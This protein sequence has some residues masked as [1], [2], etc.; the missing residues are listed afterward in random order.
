[1]RRAIIGALALLGAANSAHGQSSQVVAGR[2][3][4]DSITPLAGAIVSVT[5]APDRMFKQD[6]TGPDGRWRIRFEKAS[7]DYLVHIAA[8]GRTSFRKRVTAPLSDPV[9]AVDAT[10]A[11]SVQQL[12]A[13]RVQA[14]RPKPTR[15]G[16]AFLPDG[17]SSEQ[18]PAG[19]T[20]AVTADMAGDLAAMAGSIPGLALT[21]GGG[22][23]AF[24]LDASQSST[25]LN[26]LSFPGASLPRNA[27]T[28]TRFTTSTYDPAR[29]G[30]AGVETAVTLS[31]GNI[32][33]RRTANVVLDAPALQAGDRTSRL[34]GQRVT[35]G[36]GS[37]GGSGAWVPD[38]WYYNA[39]LDIARRVSDAPTLVEAD[40]SLFPLAGVASD[41]VN[42]LLGTLA[43]LKIPASAAAAARQRTNDKL[44]FALRIDHAPYLPQSFI[45]NPRTWAVMALGNV[46]RSAAQGISLTATPGRG[47]TNTTGYGLVQAIYSAYVTDYS[48]SETRT[49]V[50]VSRQEGTP[51]LRLPSGS[52]LV[53]S[54]LPDGSLGATTLAFGGNA[55]LGSDDTQ[56]NWDTRTDYQWFARPLHRMK[57]TAGSKVEGYRSQ[58]VG[59]ALGSYGYASLADLA[60]NRPSSFTRTLGEPAREG[61]A[62]SGFASLGDQWRATPR[63]QV[64]YGARIE[65]NRYLSVPAYNP[66]LADALGV[67]TDAAPSRVHVSPRV[68]FS[69][70]YGGDRSGYNGFGVS[71]LGTKVLA[72]SGLLRGGVGEFRSALSPQLL[73]GPSVS[74][75]LPGSTRHVAC[76]GQAVP[77]AD[78]SQFMS[79]ATSIPS[80]CLT[81]AGTLAD[82][83]PQVQVV[84]P[85]YDAARSWR[86]SLGIMAVVRS[87]GIS[88]DGNVSLNLDQ[89]S[90]YD[91]NFD[92]VPRFTSGG[93]NR[94]VFV[95]ETSIDPSS[96][97]L[98]PVES[99]RSPAYGSVFSRRSDLRSVSRQLT[100]ALSP[101]TN[102]GS[103]M[104]NVA[105]S[106]GS[107]RVNR[108]G[109]DAASFGDPRALEDA[110]G[111]LDARHRFQL[112]AGKTFRRGFSFTMNVVT[113]SG[114]P[115]TPL[116]S[117][118]VNGDGMARDRAFVF[119]PAT[120]DPALAAGMRGLLASA[121]ARAR[122]CL[123][124]QLGRAAG[125]N[126]CEG[127]W[128][129]SATARVGLMNAFGTFGRR[130]NAALSITNPLSGVDRALNGGNPRGWGASV[131]P[132]ATLLIVRGFD[133]RANRFR[134]D[135]NPR[136]GGTSL[137]QT[138]VRMPFRASLD[139][140]FDLGPSHAQQQL[141]RALNRGR[142][143]RAGQRLSADSIR[144]R[145]SRN[146]PNV[147]TQIIE[148]SDSL[149]LSR[150]QVDSLR[151]ASARLVV[152]TTAI[153]QALGVEL[154]AMDDQY[155]VKR[156]TQLTEDA[157]DAA[158]ELAREQVPV[159]KAILSPLQFTMVP[160]TIQYLAKAKG[161]IQ[162]RMYSY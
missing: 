64:V 54:L 147:Y 11:S 22:V 27:N 97:F 76:V 43:A 72:P 48:L 7:G 24:G 30:F 90:V 82:A 16:D 142:A 46:N 106:L 75:G 10:L 84:D 45:A 109:F 23:T 111:D 62:W 65:A 42:R 37:I 6:T 161:K 88:L 110:R 98:S 12:T 9:V 41:S 154:A 47:A 107:I 149:L 81:S 145:F 162:I 156:A 14:A 131:S 8:L 1:M 25:T 70:R 129:A 121:P 18:M 32:N 20:G 117:G 35:G 136:F 158:W 153:W 66:A 103:Y 140:S 69:W 102:W 132:D 124:S 144:I 40:A 74:T 68:G 91:A 13:V 146:V 100:I 56:W 58:V 105:Y 39:S 26:G 155:D 95:R 36:I 4:G 51:Y 44:S 78:W 160:G 120:A 92:G 53:S 87:I 113:A 63:L 29:G 49:G 67:R 77:S 59:N 138:T 15:E 96:G 119:D 52:V 118:D 50:F 79:D 89:P 134:Y 57:F 86:A 159:I 104:L 112:Q 83:A 152:K 143:G 17:V 5:M 115:Y 73:G 61:T 60:A 148:Q 127:P 108:R 19:V 123:R 80:S 93:E 55:A 130:V 99:R 94:P 85:S 34:L 116:V 157:T 135:V 71:N 125:I 33:T 133:A 150:E 141:E 38:K 28:T 137:S 31:P 21:P 101:Q 3:L 122:E 139:V 151:A 114:L 2:V 126:S 128:S